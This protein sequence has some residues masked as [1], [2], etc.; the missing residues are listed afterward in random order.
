MR[1]AETDDQVSI[2]SQEFVWCEPGL[3]EAH[4]H[5][6]PTLRCWL[7]ESAVKRVLDLGSGNGALTEELSQ[8]GL[9]IAGLEVSQT[10]IAI[11]RQAYPQIPFFHSGVESPLPSE[12]RNRFDAV[13]AVEV[14]EHLALPRLLFARAK[15]AL[16]PKG[17]LLIT[18]PYHG[19]LK[20]LALALTNKFDDHWHPLRDHG[21][22]KFFSFN[23]ISQLFDEQGFCVRRTARL[24]R[25][26]QFAR[27]M[28]VEGVSY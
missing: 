26:P 7:A 24:G 25:I 17:L 12:L 22:V 21:H 18:T 19:Y 4:E 16:R 1:R 9:E 10:G 28:I 6:L 13:I 23:T 2:Q 5:I 11:A 3:S 8:I 27:S 20:N 14:I 15:E